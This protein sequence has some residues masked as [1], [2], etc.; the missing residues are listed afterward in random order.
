MTGI[1]CGILGDAACPPDRRSRSV[2]FIAPP[3]TTS[4]SLR[5][6]SPPGSTRG[7]R[8]L[9]LR[10]PSLESHRASRNPRRV[11]SPWRRHAS[12]AR[13][14]G[15]HWRSVRLLRTLRPAP[16]RRTHHDLELPPRPV[17]SA[18]AAIARASSLPCPSSESISSSS[19]GATLP[20]FRRRAV[21]KPPSDAALRRRRLGGLDMEQC[22]QIRQPSSV[23]DGFRPFSVLAHAGGPLQRR[24]TERQWGEPRSRS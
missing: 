22:P 24:G 5:T 8:R 9:A 19:T 14:R 17:R 23:V 12:R 21:M 3:Q 4:A 10:L 18:P 11:P 1:G 13:S 20:R 7:P 6:Q 2:G 16:R 15:A